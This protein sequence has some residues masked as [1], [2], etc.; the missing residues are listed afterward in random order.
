[1]EQVVHAL[2]NSQKEICKSSSRSSAMSLVKARV[3]C[4]KDKDSDITLILS[5]SAMRG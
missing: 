4:H 5:L 2:A 1:M 3:L